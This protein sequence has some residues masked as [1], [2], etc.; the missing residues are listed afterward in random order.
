[1]LPFRDMY[2]S[3]IMALALKNGST[4]RRRFDLLAATGRSWKCGGAEQGDG[5][6]S[7]VEV[8]YYKREG[9]RRRREEKK[10]RK[11]EE[12]KGE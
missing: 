12:K 5:K 8:V 10:K 4:G 7:G 9:E 11:E 3:V 1:M 2:T 6:G